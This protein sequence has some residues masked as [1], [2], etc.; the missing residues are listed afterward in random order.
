MR[1]HFSPAREPASRP[2]TSDES[3]RG[4]G[5]LADLGYA[6]I[7]RL[8]AC[9]APDVRFVSRLKDNWKPKVDSSARGQVTGEFW[10]GTDLAALW[11][12]ETLVLD[13]RHGASAWRRRQAPAASQ[14]GGVQPPK[15]YCF[16]SRTC[17]LGSARCRSLTST[18]GAGRW[19][20]ASGWTSPC[21]VSTRSTPSGPAP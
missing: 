5:F 14:A 2:L 7:Q 8:R 21:T 15:G 17:P 11:E 6:S 9:E 12:D 18:A 20:A 1:F 16:V 3:W 10:P 13:G 4:C 19:N